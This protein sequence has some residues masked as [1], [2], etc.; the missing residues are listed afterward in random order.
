MDNRN[1]TLMNILYIRNLP[2]NITLIELK[3]LLEDFGD[4][5]QVRMGFTGRTKGTA[6]VVFGNSKCTEQAKLKLNGEN[7]KGKY[8][9]ALQLNYG[10]KFSSREL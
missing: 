6:F 9:I 10:Y 7:F 1:N 3:A 5:Y 4:I 2:K 8:I